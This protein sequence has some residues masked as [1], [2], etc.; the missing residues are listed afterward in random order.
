M[1]A[2]TGWNRRLENAACVTTFASDVDMRTV[3]RETGAEM[4]K[5][6]LCE[7]YRGS[8]AGAGDDQKSH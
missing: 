1:A 6:L 5:G 3:Q 7:R 2:G 4:I 8:K